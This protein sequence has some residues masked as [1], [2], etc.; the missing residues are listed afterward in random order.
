MKHFLK[1]RS[2]L[3]QLVLPIGFIGVLSLVGCNNADTQLTTRLDNL[4]KQNQDIIARIEKLEGGSAASST[5]A[6]GG[7][8]AVVAFSDLA[9]VLHPEY[10]ESLNKL[11]IFDTTG[12]DFKPYDKLT[13]GEFATWIYKTYNAIRPGNDKIQLAPQITPKFK[14][15]PKDHPAYPFVQA[16]ANNGDSVG[17][18]D[19]T[20][21]PDQPITREEAIAIKMAVQEHKDF[22]GKRGDGNC[23]KFS[24]KNQ[25]DERYWEEICEDYSWDRHNNGV[26][27]FGASKLFKP[28]EPLLRNEAASMLWQYSD[29]NAN[30]ALN[31]LA[32]NQH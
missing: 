30:M 4:E 21:K 28:K 25:I 12:T 20:F 11:G 7:T 13:R 1:S 32:K 18:T 6:S 27:A 3:A 15:V 29:W 19:G 23:L 24:D 26:R 22:P 5:Q 17:Y 16:L 2:Y 8:Q 10:I 31:E 9:G 14:D